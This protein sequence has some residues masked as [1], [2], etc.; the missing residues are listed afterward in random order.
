[1][2]RKWKWSSLTEN[3]PLFEVSPEGIFFV[4]AVGR[5]SLSRLSTL[6]CTGRL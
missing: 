2:V 3:P 6:Y 5:C 4:A 1:M